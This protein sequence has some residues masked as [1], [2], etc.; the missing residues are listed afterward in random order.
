[1]AKKI[2]SWN[3]WDGP[4]KEKIQNALANA[5]E[6]LGNT[7]KLFSVRPA[8]KDPVKF[9]TMLCVFVSMLFIMSGTVFFGFGLQK[10]QEL[11]S[12]II[13][14]QGTVS[15]LKA[16]LEQLEQYEGV[17]YEF[18]VK[19]LTLANVCGQNVV[20]VQNAYLASP[21]YTWVEDGK[22]TDEDWSA[23]YDD[24]YEEAKRVIAADTGN[25][26]AWYL[27]PWIYVSEDGTVP[28]YWQFEPIYNYSEDLVPMVWTCW[29]EGTDYLI[30]YARGNYS[31]E[32]NTVED[33]QVY[34]TSYG[35]RLYEEIS[36]Q[37]VTIDGNDG[38]LTE[39]ERLKLIE[40]FEAD[41]EMRRPDVDDTVQNVLD[42]L[43]KGDE[44]AEEAAD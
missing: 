27:P 3:D 36:D 25:Q 5:R 19:D 17:S 31:F 34:T 33:V 8:A 26:G 18:A 30:A 9:K 35:Q 7:K 43:G 20:S 28:F 12:A 24:L 11:N 38:R 29:Q 23:V 32:S 39:E 13:M 4:E 41:L 16:Q 10:G 22:M 42:A 37:L 2:Q 1:M 6:K 21:P 40:K 44:N 14:R 15:N